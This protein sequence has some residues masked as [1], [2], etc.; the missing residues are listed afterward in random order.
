MFAPISWAKTEFLSDHNAA[1]M[2][3]AEHLDDRHEVE[4]WER[5]R[6]VAQFAHR[7]GQTKTTPRNFTVERLLRE[8]QLQSKERA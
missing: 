6:P 7:P 1:A 8:V 4:L 2:K 5:G 3:V